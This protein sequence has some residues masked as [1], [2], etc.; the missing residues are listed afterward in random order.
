VGKRNDTHTQITISGIGFDRTL[1]GQILDFKLQKLFADEFQKK[2]GD[3][4]GVNVHESP[5]AMAKLMKEANRIK[6]VLSANQEATA[7]V[8]PVHLDSRAQ[9]FIRNLRLS[10][11][12]KTLIFDIRSNERI[13]KPCR[14]TLSN[15]LGSQW[16]MLLLRQD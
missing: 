10:R 14:M 5:R 1:G 4:N 13:L 9:C 3:K 8:N 16:M 7:M 2:T 11:S 12:L 6:H 15:E